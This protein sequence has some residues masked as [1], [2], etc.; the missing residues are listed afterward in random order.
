MAFRHYRERGRGDVSPQ[1]EPL[2]VMRP[3]PPDQISPLIVSVESG[4]VTRGPK[5][6]FGAG[7]CG[8]DTDRVDRKRRSIFHWT[9]DASVT[10][11]CAPPFLP[12]SLAL[13]RRVP[14]PSPLSFR[15]VSFHEDVGES[16]CEDL[17]CHC[18]F[19]RSL[20]SF[21]LFEN[22]PQ[23]NGDSPSYSEVFPSWAR[24]FDTMM[25]VQ[26]LGSIPM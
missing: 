6:A 22:P 7:E 20:D 5:C 2:F 3:P 1:R 16:I 25:M 17:E 14:L 4:A 12:P 18:L 13:I 21:I 11:I 9:T 19:S 26:H 10:S 8:L 23:R 24:S 15:S